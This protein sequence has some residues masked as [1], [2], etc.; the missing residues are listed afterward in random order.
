MMVMV[1][2][3]YTKEDEGCRTDFFFFNIQNEAQNL[4]VVLRCP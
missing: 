2:K 1:S 4:Q 3:T